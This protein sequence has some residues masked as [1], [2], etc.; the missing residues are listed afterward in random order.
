MS[1]DDLVPQVN[2]KHI[3]NCVSL[4]LRT[5]DNFSKCNFCYYHG[6]CLKLRTAVVEN[7]KLMTLLNL[8]EDTKKRLTEKFLQFLF[9]GKGKKGMDI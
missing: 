2:E 3:F 6:D 9:D 4:R 1:L 8:G 7:P 5:S